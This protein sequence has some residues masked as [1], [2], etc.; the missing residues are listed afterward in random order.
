[1]WITWQAPVV[2]FLDPVWFFF[3]VYYIVL[4]KLPNFHF[5]SD[6]GQTVGVCF[7]L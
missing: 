4:D 7:L 2:L 6:T 1:M 5:K 3:T